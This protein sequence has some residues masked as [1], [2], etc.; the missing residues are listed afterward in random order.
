MHS[1]DL[2]RVAPV[3]CSE[4]QTVIN[5]FCVIMSVDCC[6]NQMRLREDDGRLIKT[7]KTELLKLYFCL[8]T[9]LF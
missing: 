4:L 3:L 8:V 1:E 6:K 2:P 5:L 9:N 7:L